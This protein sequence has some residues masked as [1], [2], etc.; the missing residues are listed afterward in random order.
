MKKLYFLI[1]ILLAF[2]TSISAQGTIKRPLEKAFDAMRS[3]YWYEAK[4]FAEADGQVARDIILWH[5]FRA[6]R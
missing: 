3:G 1:S 4:Q 5:E 6:G 2:S